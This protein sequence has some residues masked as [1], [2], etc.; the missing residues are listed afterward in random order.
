MAAFV[1]R[2]TLRPFELT[3][4]NGKWGQGFIIHTPDDWILSKNRRAERSRFLDEKLSAG[5]IGCGND[6]VEA[7]ITARIIP[8]WIE[9]ESHFAIPFHA[10]AA[11][12]PQQ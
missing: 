12:A 10:G 2:V 9:A 1:S 3:R 11:K 7:L 6:L 8:A 4:R 5:G